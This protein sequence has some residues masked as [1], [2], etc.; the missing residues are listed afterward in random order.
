MASKQAREEVA[1]AAKDLGHLHESYSSGEKPGAVKE[2]SYRLGLRRDALAKHIDDVPPML[3][4]FKHARFARLTETL[5]NMA[6]EWLSVNKPKPAVAKKKGAAK[7]K[8]APQPKPAPKPKTKATK[9]KAPV[10]EATE[11]QP[12][13]Q[14]V[15]ARRIGNA[16]RKLQ[17]ARRFELYAELHD[18]NKPP[19][20]AAVSQ[21]VGAIAAAL[22]GRELPEDVVSKLSRS[23]RSNGER[24]P[25]RIDTIVECVL[26]PGG[27]TLLEVAEALL[28]RYPNLSGRWQ[29]KPASVEQYQRYARTA[30]WHL[31][32]GKT[33]EVAKQFEGLV[34]RTDDKPPRYYI[35]GQTEM[36][37]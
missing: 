17:R 35:E 16:V 19:R 12:Q 4:S 9:V 25:R 24:A 27:A 31:N 29:G 5:L 33:M 3:K 6:N 26:S 20:G 1:K 37:S 8:P 23:R 18:G 7:P 28:E 11:E 10:T 22:V 36:S 30:M 21:I 32:S 13:P 15:S 2:V 14:E 34:R